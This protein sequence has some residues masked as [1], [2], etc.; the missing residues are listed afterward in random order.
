[1]KETKAPAGYQ[2]LGKIV[3]FEVNAGSYG[4]NLEIENRTRPVIPETGGIGT[5]IFLVT[6]SALMFLVYK[7]YK[8]QTAK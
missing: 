4:S 1:M 5:L 6:G 2:L 3:P 7:G 8:R